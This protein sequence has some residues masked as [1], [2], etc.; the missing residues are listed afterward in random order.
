[1]DIYG[2]PIVTNIYWPGSVVGIATSYG[3]DSMGLESREGKEIFLF[4]KSTQA[5]SRAHCIQSVLGFF[6]AVIGRV[7]KLITHL[8]LV[9]RLQMSGGTL[10]LPLYILKTWTRKNLPLSCQQLI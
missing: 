9:P 10:L 8:Y 3:L 4:S 2:I 5:G 1:M 6:P 7:V